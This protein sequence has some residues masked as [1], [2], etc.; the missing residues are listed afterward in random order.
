MIKWLI[1]KIFD[2]IGLLAGLEIKE[3]NIFCMQ[4]GY[5]KVDRKYFV[6]CYVI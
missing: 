3:K 4:S 1:F 5:K 6:K 2:F